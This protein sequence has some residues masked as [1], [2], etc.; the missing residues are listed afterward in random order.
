MFGEFDFTYYLEQLDW[1]SG[2]DILLVAAIIFGV[3]TLVSGTRAVPML[4][5]LLVFSLVLVLLDSLV[6]PLTALRWLVGRILPAL[7]L[8]IPIIFQ[9][10]LR[11]ALTQLGQP[12]RFARFWKREQEDPTVPIL[13]DTARRLSTRRHGAL[14]IIERDTG[15]KEYIDTGVQLDAEINTPLLLNIFYKDAD[16][17]DGGVI[18]KDGRIAAASCVMPLSNSRMSERQM[19]LRHRAAL[20]TSENSD[21][22]VIVVSEETGN[23]AIAHNGRILPKLPAH[24]LESNLQAFLNPQLQNG[25]A[26]AEK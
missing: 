16:L 12:A 25:A 6:A 23:I 10:E 5:G 4:R 9:P 1:V 14:I 11:R 24:Q 17:H 8:A 19:G 15:L 20:G 22:V 7:F 2:L 26:S 21:A 18:I 3:L 13:A